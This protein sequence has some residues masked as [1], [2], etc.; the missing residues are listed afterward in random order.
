MPFYGD[1]FWDWASVVNALTEVRSTSPSAERA[2]AREMDS[3]REVVGKR[4]PTGLTVGNPDREWYG[5]ATAAITYRVLGKGSDDTPGIQQLLGVLKAQA[6]ETA[7]DDKYHGREIPS[8][9]LLWHYGQ[10]IALFPTEA[11]EQ[12]ERL[13]NLS[14]SKDAMEDDERV[15]VLARVLQGAYAADKFD[16]IEQALSQLYKAQNLNRPLG[17]GLMGDVIKGL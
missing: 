5:P 14:W 1:D 3:F 7:V 10:V 16:T 8:R 11:R 6:L 4:A 15:F 17:Y 2:A 9:Q 12:V 13:T